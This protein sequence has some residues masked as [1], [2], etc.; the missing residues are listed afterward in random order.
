MIVS[1]KDINKPFVPFDLTIRVESN[2]EVKALYCIF[3]HPGITDWVSSRGVDDNAMRD[4]LGSENYD[5]RL[6]QKFVKFLKG[7]E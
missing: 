2:E 4:N 1:R 7:R 6:H 3:N 5:S